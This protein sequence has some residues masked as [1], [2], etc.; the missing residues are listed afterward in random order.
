MKKTSEEKT[1]KK[2][3]GKKQ[4]FQRRG[5]KQGGREGENTQE[6]YGLHVSSGVGKKMNVGANQVPSSR[7]RKTKKRGSHKSSSKRGFEA[8]KGS[9]GDEGRKWRHK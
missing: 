4:K 8:S 5:P 3:A 7:K 9:H 1:L 6:R 2:N